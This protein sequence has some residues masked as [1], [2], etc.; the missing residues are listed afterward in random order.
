MGLILL[1]ACRWELSFPSLTLVFTLNAALNLTQS[2]EYNFPL[3]G[4]A[5]LAGLA[6]DLWLKLLRPSASKPWALRLFGFTVPILLYGAFFTVLMFTGA[7]GWSAHLWVGSILLAGI[8][9]W[10]LSYLLVPPSGK[11]ASPS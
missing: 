1:T 4:A 8:I 11:R 2:P 6:A 3:L 10:L 9:G 7:I 5:A